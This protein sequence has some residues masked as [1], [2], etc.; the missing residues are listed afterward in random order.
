M[1]ER[2][3]QKEP[4]QNSVQALSRESSCLPRFTEAPVTERVESAEPEMGTRD[5]HRQGGAEGLDTNVRDPRTLGGHQLPSTAA[6]VSAAAEHPLGPQSFGSCLRT[7]PPPGLLCP[8]QVSRGLSYPPTSWDGVRGACQS[9]GFPGSKVWFSRGASENSRGEGRGP[10]K[11]PSSS[12]PPR[13]V[14][15]GGLQSTWSR[16]LKAQ[17]REM[18]TRSRRLTHRLKRKRPD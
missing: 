14:G 7:V 8:G 18:Q 16:V 2:P 11:E 13:G 17:A 12:R 9:K 3:R 1:D 15:K 10:E 6:S 4:E 5:M